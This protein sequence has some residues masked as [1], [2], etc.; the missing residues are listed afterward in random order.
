[1]E[2]E[3]V[4][5]C[6]S[7]VIIEEPA[8]GRISYFGIKSMTNEKLVIGQDLEHR[9][10]SRLSTL[11]SNSTFASWIQQDSAQDVDD[12]ISFMT[13]FIMNRLL[14][15][16]RRQAS[17][18]A[19]RNKLILGRAPFCA[20]QESTPTSAQASPSQSR[21]LSTSR[22]LYQGPNVQAVASTTAQEDGGVSAPD[23]LSEG[24]LEVFNKLKRELEPTKLE[25]R[26]RMPTDQEKAV[27]QLPE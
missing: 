11:S 18:L 23:Y 8:P 9:L 19:T 12:S 20:A 1:M 26:L 7:V 2:V 16:A 3:C 15:T 25:V 17:R 10:M 13:V 5:L 4:V 22:T 24:E 6:A 27:L 14:P 21:C